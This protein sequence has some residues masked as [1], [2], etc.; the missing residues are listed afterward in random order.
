M[1]RFQFRRACRLR[2]NKRITS[3][4]LLKLLRLAVAVPTKVY[5]IL[6]SVRFLCTSKKE[7]KK[8]K[9]KRK[10]IYTMNSPYLAYK[11]N[12]YITKIFKNAKFYCDLGTDANDYIHY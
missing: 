9:K 7:T 5:S 1:F 6:L 12:C 4:Y 8:K 11:K 10:E 3:P 2:C